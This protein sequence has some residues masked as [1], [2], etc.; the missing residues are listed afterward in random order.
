MGA[1]REVLLTTDASLQHLHPA[2]LPPGTVVG[3]WCVRSRQSCGAYGAVYLASRASEQEGALFALKVALHPNDPRFQREAELLRRIAHPHVPRLHEHGLWVHPAGPFPFLVMDR[4]EG[5]PLE[6][7]AHE[8]TRTS[9]QVMRLLAPVAGALAAT[10]AV[11]GVHRDVKGDNILVRQEDSWPTLLDFG[12]GDFLGAPTLTRE[13]LP[14]GTPYHRSPEALRFHW[15]N[16]QVPGAHYKPGPADDIYALGVTAYCLVTGTY[17]PPVLPPELLASDPSFRPPV[18]EPPENLVTVCPELAALIRQMLSLEPS[19]RGSAAELAQAFEQAA[20][21]PGPE[22]DQ[23]IVP[24]TSGKAG[25]AS[26]AEAP[27][28]AVLVAGPPVNQPR[29]QSAGVAPDARKNQ[30]DPRGAARVPWPWL[31]VTAG[32]VAFLALQVAGSKRH[33]ARPIAGDLADHSQ[34]NSGEEAGTSGLGHAA[35]V[36]C[37]GTE[38]SAISGKQIGVNVP[39]T[40]LPGQAR[41]PCKKPEMVI[42]GGCWGRP[43][44]PPC[45]EREYEW[46]G[47]CYA[48]VLDP[49]PPATSEQR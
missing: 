4:A 25:V 32:L 27:A 17:P 30:P 40:P 33:P 37:G 12:A 34:D 47:L 3:S 43:A 22:T 18:W 2:H 39:K 1:S 21:S 44:A 49:S 11:K 35:L 24:Q 10:H 8:R 36:T 38:E 15:L 41:P 26:R 42:N 16:R 45:G 29:I 48:P 28:P 23:P 31:A 9:R 5:V 6:V 13:L 19:A 7:W 20:R 14:P 46:R